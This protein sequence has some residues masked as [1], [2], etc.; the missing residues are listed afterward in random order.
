MERAVTIAHHAETAGTAVNAVSADYAKKL[1][2]ARKII[3]S[4]DVA[5]ELT[6]DGA[7]DVIAELKLNVSAEE[8]E[9]GINLIA[10]I[11]GKKYK[12]VGMEV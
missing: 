11:G 7:A 6:F 5:G 4:G 10:S 1:A 2:T 9:G 12:F 8:I 3:F